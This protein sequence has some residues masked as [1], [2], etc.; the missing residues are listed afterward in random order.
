MNIF[1]PLVLRPQSCHGLLV[2]E[3]SNSQNDAPQSV[4]L[5]GTSDRL[6]A[7]A[8]YLTTHNTHKRQ[9]SIPPVGIEPTIPG[10]E[11]S[12]ILDRAIGGIGR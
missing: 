1:S 11:R 7:E 9:T 10:S 12:Q 3:V 2:H 8:S 6:I 5:L 4:G